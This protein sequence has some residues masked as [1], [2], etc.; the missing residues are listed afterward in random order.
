[1]REK[2]E[3]NEKKKIWEEVDEEQRKSQHKKGYYNL[4]DIENI[5]RQEAQYTSDMF[6]QECIGR[7]KT[8]IY[9]QCVNMWNEKAILNERALTNVKRRTEVIERANGAVRV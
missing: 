8:V 3:E 1:M 7:V 2:A 4:N 6:S 9:Y 5:F